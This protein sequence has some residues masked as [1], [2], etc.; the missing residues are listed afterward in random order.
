M[1]AECRARS[2]E[3][4]VSRRLELSDEFGERLILFDRDAADALGGDDL[5]FDD[6][7]GDGEDELFDSAV[8]V[9]DREGHRE[10]EDVADLLDAEIDVAVLARAGGGADPR[11]AGAKNPAIEEA[12]ERLAGR[13]LEGQPQIVR[14]RLAEAEVTI[15]A[16]QAAEERLVAD[17]RPQHVQRHGRL[18][19][20]QPA[21]DPAVVLDVAEAVAE[22]DRTLP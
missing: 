16:L 12:L 22:V 18:V 6:G 5:V 8:D 1:V 14:A 13:R 11:D 20:D 15:E 10:I 3:S 4:R 17:E 19:V 7:L 21:E 2:V 9:R